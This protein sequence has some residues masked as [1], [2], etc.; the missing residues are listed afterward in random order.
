MCSKCVHS[1]HSSAAAATTTTTTIATAKKKVIV[2]VRR[3]WWLAE[4]KEKK[5]EMDKEPFN[6][7]NFLPFDG[8]VCAGVWPTNVRHAMS[9]MEI[10]QD[11]RRHIVEYRNFLWLIRNTERS[12]QKLTESTF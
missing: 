3:C 12:W 2:C 9:R 7:I 1:L 5:V 8:S 11:F 10:Q 4:K 6:G